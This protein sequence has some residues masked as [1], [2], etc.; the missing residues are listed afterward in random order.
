MAKSDLLSDSAI[1]SALEQLPAWERKASKLHRE[2]KFQDFV[3][4][5]AF[6]AAVA[7]LAETVNH[8]PEWSN[9]WNRVTVDLSTHDA[10]G[11]T[12]LDVELAAK[13][14]AI[15]QKLL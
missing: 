3:G 14:E 6:M 15:A 4:A 7:I 2:Y 1:Q 5:F 12:G 11:I 9:V 8:H 13:M 10:G